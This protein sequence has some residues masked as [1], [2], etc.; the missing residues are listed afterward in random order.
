[1]KDTYQIVKKPLISE[2]GLALKEV[3]NKYTFQVDFTAN[4]TE[5][6]KALE[7][8]FPEIKGKIISINTVSMK[9]KQIRLRF[10]EGKRPD[11]KKA[12]VTLQKGTEISIYE[13]I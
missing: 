9:G 8:F 11:W 2:K 13:A 4:K 5:I 6:K 10:K 1:M 3:R 12:I 7:E